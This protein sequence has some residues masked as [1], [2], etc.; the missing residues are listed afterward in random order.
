[1]RL[2]A[3][4]TMLVMADALVA[5]ARAQMRSH[6]F[7]AMKDLNSGGR[8]ADLHRFAGQRVRH[9]VP[10]TVEGHVI[11][12]VHARLRPL[13]QVVTVAGNGCKAGWSIFANRLAR[14]SSLRL[15]NGRLFR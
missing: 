12:D 2:M 15:R 6:A 9:A 14:H 5:F 4:R 1:M 10:V 11:I 8:G 3:L 7:A 13:A